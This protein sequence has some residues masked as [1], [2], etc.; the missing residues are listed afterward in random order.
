MDLIFLDINMPDI[1]G[2]QLVQTLS[3]R[4]MIIFTTA[5]SHYAVES[6]DL[7]ALDYLLKLSLLSA[8]LQP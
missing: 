1:S 6:Y 7:N 3:P 4:P 5:Y 8:F 2:M